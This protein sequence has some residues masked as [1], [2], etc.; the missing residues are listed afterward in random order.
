MINNK[1]IDILSK[2][3]GYSSFRPHQEDIINSILSGRNTVVLMPT[4]GGKSLCYQIPALVK[5]GTAIVISP[6]IALMKDQVDALRVNG[7]SAA[8]LNSTQSHEE[9]A[10]I[11]SHLRSGEIKLL[12]LAPERL[13]GRENQF[14]NFIKGL[15]ISLIAI[16]EAHCISS[17]GHDFR[18]EYLLLAHVKKALNNIPVIAL[19]AT[20]DELT[21]KDIIEKLEL[22]NPEIFVT[23]FNRPNIQYLVKP[24]A[25]SYLQL[26]EFLSQQKDESG[27]IYNLRRR[28]TE[29]LAEQLN[30]D[31]FSAKP[32][33]AGLDRKVRNRHQEL[34]LK[35]D[36]KIVVATIAFGMGI[37]KSNVR[38]VVHMDLPKNIESY[39]QETG[40][41]GRDGL[42]STALMFYSYADYFAMQKL[43]EVPENPEQSAVM[44]EKLQQMTNYGSLKTCRRKYLLEYF[45]EKAEPKCDNCDNCL[46]EFEKIDATEIAQ[47]ALSA[48]ARLEQRFGVNYIIDF[49][50]GSKSVKI[51]G[52]HKQLK[53]YGVGADM[54][55]DEWRHYINELIY[56][57][58][59]ERS[60]GQY[61]VLELADKSAD[62]LK[63]KTKVEL[64]KAE[65]EQPVFTNEKTADV[66]TELVQNIKSCRKMLADSEG[67]PAFVVFSDAT[68]YELATYLPQN[69]EELIRI[70]GFGEVKVRRYGEIIL[71]EIKQYCSKHQLSSNM[72]S[73]LRKPGRKSQVEAGETCMK[74]FELYQSGKNISEIARARGLATGTIESHVDKLIRQGKL[75]AEDMLEEAT[76]NIIKEALKRKRGLGLKPVKE[77]LGDAFSYGEIKIVAAEMAFQKKEK[78]TP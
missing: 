35:D 3:F 34:F 64:S 63:G 1:P 74:T 8:Y 68:L 16:D 25:N 66:H 37:D 59:L 51:R 78:Q 40:R 44:K 17:W 26:V 65:D 27:I 32:Y 20:A 69:P 55:K 24:K 23:G 41:A 4:G 14:M 52:E 72:P 67:V 70:S 13:L 73:T 48:V 58:F 38:Y 54:T 45:G 12:Y 11:F 50:R 33:H 30:A 19:T 9:Q 22:P 75:R 60:K 29:E 10:Q 76:I 21:Q 46:H 18:P 62:A 49:L 5:E 56:E 36:V 15:N 31:G 71:N 39:Y 53:T 57:G 42:P 47:K 28:D 77:E 61:P 43:V 7:V 2:V 6:L